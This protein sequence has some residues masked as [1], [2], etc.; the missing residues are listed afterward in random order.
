[1][2]SQLISIIIVNHNGIRFLK[3]CLKSI[4][5]QSYSDFEVILVDNGS[6]DG[7]VQFVKE[8]FPGVIMIE[9][10]ENLGFAI[11]NNQ[12][13]ELSKG[14]YIAL[15]NNDTVVDKDWLKNLVSVAESS[16]K[17]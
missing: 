3:D 16:F 7:S 17:K 15:L 6:T 10:K 5:Q 8:N 11:S 9:N 12:G 1:L 4:Y 2:S 14:K 13:I